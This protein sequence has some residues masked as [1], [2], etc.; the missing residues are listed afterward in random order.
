LGNALVSGILL[1]SQHFVNNFLKVNRF[2]VV[3]KNATFL[4]YFRRKMFQNSGEVSVSRE[5]VLVFFFYIKKIFLAVL[6]Y[7]AVKQ[8]LVEV[9]QKTHKNAVVEDPRVIKRVKTN[10]ERF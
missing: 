4:T 10:F 7:V 8:S 2:A 1:Y 3:E 9:I 6:K 5:K